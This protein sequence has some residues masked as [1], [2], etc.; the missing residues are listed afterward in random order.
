VEA[1]RE[2]EPKAGSPCLARREAADGRIEAAADPRREAY[3]LG[4]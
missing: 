3:A 4:W 1:W 2:W